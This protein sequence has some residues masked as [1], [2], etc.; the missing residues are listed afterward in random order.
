M[1]STIQKDAPVGILSREQEKNGSIIKRFS[2][3]DHLG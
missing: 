2:Y 1:I 3:Q